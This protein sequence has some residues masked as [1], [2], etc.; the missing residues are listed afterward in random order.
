MENLKCTLDDFYYLLGVPIKYFDKDW[1][2]ILSKGYDQNLN[3]YF[4]NL[5]VLK[6]C[7]ENKDSYAEISYDNIHFLKFNILGG[8]NLKGYFIIGPF[9]SDYCSYEN[10]LPF[11]PHN[12]I[13]Y[14]K[15]LFNTLTRDNLG[16]SNNYSHYIT[17]AIMYIHK[18]YD[19][20]ISI[21]DVCK[22]LGLNKSYFCSLFKKETSLTFCNFLNMFRIEMSK[23]FLCNKKYSIMDVSLS[24]GYNNHNY[25]SSL[26]KKLNNI[27]PLEYRK[28]SLNKMS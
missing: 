23:K 10:S 25:Y 5:N 28:I 14:I 15:D 21:D 18:N 16:N 2:N 12:C 7:K 17:Q 24:V 13:K 6:N 3:S 26:F 19:K 11:K 20:D 8:K 22:F 1:N 9:S 27:T 4:D